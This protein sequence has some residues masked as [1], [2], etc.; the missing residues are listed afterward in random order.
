MSKKLLIIIVVIL[1]ACGN[2]NNIK[3][4]KTNEEIKTSNYNLNNKLANKISKNTF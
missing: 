4:N 3:I 1:S 2:D